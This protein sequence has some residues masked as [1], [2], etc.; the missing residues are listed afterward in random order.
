M[1]VD[2]EVNAQDA[3]IQVLRLIDFLS[4]Y[5]AQRNKPVRNISDYRLFRLTE[6]DL[7][8]H[9][10]VQVHAAE[11]EWL[12]IDFVDLPPAPRVP[13]ELMEY[14]AGGRPVSA[15][16]RPDVTVPLPEFQTLSSQGGDENEHV[17]EFS[18]EEQQV[19][20]EQ[21]E[22]LVCD[23]EGW[24][25]GQWEPW[26]AEHARASSVK[27]RHR[28]LFEQRERLMLDRE[29][30]ELVWGF[31][32][33]RWAIEGYVLDHPLI[34]VPVEISLDPKSQRLAVTPAGQAEVEIRYLAGL[35][36]HDRQS[37]TSARQTTAELELDPWDVKEMSELLLRLTRS[38]DDN[39]VLEA[40]AGTPASTLV[41]DQS[42]TLFLRPRVPDS[43]GF[44]DEMRAIYL[45]DGIIPEPL[46]DVVSH[47]GGESQGAEIQTNPDNFARRAPADPLLLPLATNEEQKRIL[48]LAQ[49]HPGVTVQG[50]PGT[51]KSH[52][53]ANLISHY[54]AYGQ[55][56]LVVA[57][58]EQALKVLSDKIPSGIRDLTVSVLGADE[59]SRKSLEKAV[60]TIQGTVGTLDTRGAD[61]TI[62]RLRLDLDAANRGI[63]A[64]TTDMLRARQAEIERAPGSWIVGENPSP[65]LAA[66]W[67]QQNTESFAHIPDTLELSAPIPFSAA[68]YAG[69]LELLNSVGIK[70]A[71][72]ALTILPPLAEIPTAAELANL[73]KAA[74]ESQGRAAAVRSMFTSWSLFTAA[75]RDIITAVQAQTA[76]Y[77]EALSGIEASPYAA[78]LA[79]LD[80]ELL[81]Q[82]LTDYFKALTDLRHQAIQ[83]RRALM[84]S[85]V[86]LEVPATQDG[87]NRIIDAQKH[88][89]TTGKLGLFDRQHK[90][91]LSIFTIDGRVPST[92]DEASLCI[93]ATLLDL[94]RQHISRLFVN[95]SPSAL[96]VTLTAR[97]EDDVANELRQLEDLLG[98]PARRH[99]LSTQLRSV[100]IRTSALSS[101][102]QSGCLVRDMD[103]AR[104]HFDAVESVT[105]I[106]S[107]E[108]MLKAGGNR[109]DASPLWVQLLEALQ[110]QDVERWS[111]LLDETTRV[112]A[113]VEPA[114]RLMELHNAV[115]GAAPKWAAALSSAPDKAPAAETINGA[116]QWRQ[117]DCWVA[118]TTSQAS[119]AELQSRIDEH[120]RQ[121]QRTVAELVEALAWRRLADNLGPKQRQALQGYLKAVTRYGK[122]GGKYAQ[123]WIREMREALND[124][125]DA[126]PV[127]IMTTSRA[128]T[129][130][131]PAAI[132]PFDVLIVD[133][134]SQIGFEALPLLSLAKKAIV[135]GDDKQTSPEH[136]GLDRQK[137]FDI[138]D[139][140]LAEVPKYRTL[141]DPDNSLY[142]LATQKFATPVMLSEHF[143]CLPEIIAFSNTQA[144]NRRIVPLRD[145]APRPGWV[146]LGV[147]RVMD[148]YRM[149]DV[150]EPEALQAAN[151]IADMC[152]DE[153]YDGMTFGVVT[154][155]GSSQAK[156]I[157]EKLYDRLGPEQLEERKIRCGEA[158]NFQGDERD[159]I[160]ISTVV[161]IDPSQST[162]RFG[163]MTSV[164]D[165]RKINVAASRARNQMWVVTSVDPEM[166]PNGDL[167]AAL[168]RHCA[169]YVAEAPAQEELLD[170]C[171]S[172]F[173]RR[174]VSALL[175]RGYRAVEVQKTVGRYRLDIVVSGPERRLAIECDGD[176]WHGPDVWHQDRARQE[177][178]ERAGWTFERIR[179]SAFFRDPDA[180]MVSVWSHLDSLGIPTGGG[181]MEGPKSSVV[182]EV[183]MADLPGASDE[184]ESSAANS[185][186]YE[187]PD[188][189][190]DEFLE[191]LD[192]PS[193]FQ[194]GP[195]EVPAPEAPAEGTT[196]SS[197]EEPTVGVQAEVVPEPLTEDDDDTSA[198]LFGQ[199]AEP[200]TEYV[201]LA[202]YTPWP[203]VPK[204]PVN[205]RNIQHI[206]QGLVEILRHEGPMI[207][208]QVYLRYQQAAGG[209]RVGKSLQSIFNVA[210]SRALRA[211]A[212]ARLDDGVQGVVGSTLYIPGQDPVQV[213]QLGPRT[214][215]EVPPSEL[216]TLFELITERGVPEWDLDREVLNALGL[217]RLTKRTADYLQECRSYTWKIT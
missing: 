27:R 42:W 171:E 130:F 10:A 214:I 157:W 71:R 202:L 194:A 142:D 76:E 196:P 181:W 7:P 145:Q 9:S 13:E 148:G 61:E 94:T 72:R 175:G 48:E 86:E 49:I 100:G 119:P 91:T 5:D 200:S 163:A 21:Y 146:P 23:A 78:K 3:R 80:D 209:Q 12:S 152:D 56:V 203:L 172:V 193:P 123:R 164:K 199:E 192:A 65:Q 29:S 195:G 36:I 208:R 173:E 106:E 197:E 128:L 62:E 216:T 102:E 2:A 101:A 109:L 217:K 46:R 189:D 22:Q 84:S 117:L 75:S 159:V 166:L 15:V 32:R 167:R 160:V 17:Q 118:S 124:S 143:R 186:V 90:K 184:S 89:S 37:I 121:R 201:N 205:D 188:F 6:N 114:S 165:L 138:M 34:T 11:P 115:I 133:E 20:L 52:T 113:L 26:S 168:I 1:T 111:R 183:T 141:F 93:A 105:R 47:A 179:G 97:P 108:T 147:L 68:E 182:R 206:Q 204:P 87:L 41:A 40:S 110:I 95:Q 180:A 140:H 28:N 174:V 74:A 98:L 125:K 50:P 57:E 92:R 82:E 88:L 24:I 207:A 77:C 126:V 44:L 19:Q 150:N 35:D 43:Q 14:I 45:A 129:S 210:A 191:S 31:G 99:Q 81:R 53:I 59:E 73:F 135:V 185:S 151:L 176:R 162:T 187:D 131:R 112:T 169:S 51:G 213:R 134:A 18:E 79:S 8:T 190:W 16:A 215:F 132:P 149:G 211:G 67:V 144:Y 155:L 64:T 103:E 158:A 139:D 116:W 156:L 60:T 70:Q 54:V 66:E 104:Q 120:V 178:L 170:A 136:V 25:Q 55:R 122:T 85:V 212:I 30:V 137:I 96:Q 69:Y 33:A 83:H 4:E 107:L 39:G 38:I 198:R 177:V 127:W 58:K 153:Q 154:L 161:A 63:A